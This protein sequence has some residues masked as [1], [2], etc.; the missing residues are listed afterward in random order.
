MGHL[1]DPP[2]RAGKHEVPLLAGH[3]RGY[4]V[5]VPPGLQKLG[6]EL[7]RSGI[8]VHKNQE[9]RKEHIAS[10]NQMDWLTLVREHQKS[11]GSQ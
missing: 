5:D 9:Q 8:F 11:E 10:E 6:F 7:G 2:I 1:E 4:S 3:P